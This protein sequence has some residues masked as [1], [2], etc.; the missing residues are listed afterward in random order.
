MSEKPEYKYV[1]VP[2]G[3]WVSSWRWWLV[4]QLRALFG[5]AT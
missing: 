2:N 3:R 4:K 1:F 5:L